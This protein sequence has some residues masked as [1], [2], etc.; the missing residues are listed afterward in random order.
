MAS[1]DTSSTREVYLGGIMVI[2]ESK[3]AQ[4]QRSRTD[5]Q[6]HGLDAWEWD[7]LP[8]PHRRTR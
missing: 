2:E 1:L 6:T 5:E 4:T 8:Q 3:E 7:R